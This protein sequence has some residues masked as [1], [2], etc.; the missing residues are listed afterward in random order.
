VSHFVPISRAGFA[1]ALARRLADAPK[2][3]RVALDGAPCTEPQSWAEEL[4]EALRTLGRP[5]AHVRAASFWRDASVRLEYGHQDVD[6]YLTWLDPAALRREVL[7]PVAVTGQ[8]LPSLRDARTNRA[9]RQPRQH[10]GERGVLVVSG[11]LLLGLGLPFDLTIHLAASPAALA[12]R[13]SPDQAWTLP[14]FARY[15]AQADPQLTSDVVVRVEDPLRPA[16]RGL[17]SGK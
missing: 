16:V 4:T 12:R 1:A 10:L 7:E 8:F 2:T 17:A 11:S 5:V 3:T 15:Q 9:T 14:A 13:T 6:A